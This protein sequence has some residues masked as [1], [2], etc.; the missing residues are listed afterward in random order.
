V[1]LFTCNGTDAQPWMRSGHTCRAL[2]MCLEVSGAGIVN[3]TRV[4]LSHCNQS[5]AQ[6]WM[7]SIGQLIN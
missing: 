3:G 7:Y 1:Q 4:E 2:G 6:T 5:G